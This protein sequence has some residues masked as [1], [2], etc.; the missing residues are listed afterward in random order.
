M[1]S[2]AV[3]VVYLAFVVAG[4]GYCLLLGLLHR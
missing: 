3:F 4:L 2:R 1:R